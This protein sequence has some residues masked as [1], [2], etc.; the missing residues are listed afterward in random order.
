MIDATRLGFEPFLGWPV[1]WAVVALAGTEPVN[2]H[3]I[4]Y[5]NRLSDWFFVASRAANTDGDGDILW[6]P[7][8]NR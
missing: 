2:P 4:R 8:A 5:L 6:V 3:A 1:V 7:G